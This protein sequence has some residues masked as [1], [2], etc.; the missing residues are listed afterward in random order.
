[1]PT[2][3]SHPAVPLAIA[4]GLGSGVI[5]RRLLVAGIACS[6][7]PDLDVYFGSTVASG[8]A[9][10]HRGF[11]HS[12]PF[13][14]IC[15]LAA[16]PAARWL[17]ATPL[18]AFFFISVC[19]ASHGLLDAFTN[20]GPGI[21]FF[22]PFSAE[23]YF[24]PVQRVEV[25]PIGILRFFSLRG[26]YVLYSELKWVWLPAAAIALAMYSLRKT[27]HPREGGNPGK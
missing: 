17:R 25:S 26:T 8:S 13:A 27:R 2:I 11:T 9:L 12:L 3:L 21:Q 18:A 5:S 20:G 6:I 15:G 24:L 1:V 4:A 10:A 23:R 7:A 19:T 16:L 22:W 14:F